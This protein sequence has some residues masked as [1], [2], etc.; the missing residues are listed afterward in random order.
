MK[1]VA[2]AFEK[3]GCYYP[4]KQCHTPWEGNHPLSRCENLETL[5]PRVSFL[6]SCFYFCLPFFLGLFTLFLHLPIHSPVCLSICGV[7]L[8][9]PH[10]FL[11]A[12]LAHYDSGHNQDTAPSRCRVDTAHRNLAYF[13]PVKGIGLQ[14]L[15]QLMQPKI[16]SRVTELL[17]WDECS[18]S[19]WTAIHDSLLKKFALTTSALSIFTTIFMPDERYWLVRRA[20]N[21]TIFFFYILL[22]V[23]LVTNSC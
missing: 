3:S 5:M 17:G 20:D 15:K 7:S 4:V 21:H 12:N 18:I 16:A 19:R 11:C 1:R 6:H 8:N 10:F 14:S 22:T 23:H 13:A 2:L 9:F